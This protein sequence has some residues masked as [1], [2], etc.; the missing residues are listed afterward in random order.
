MKGNRAVL[1]MSKHL[2]IGALVLVVAY[3]FFE[4]YGAK[5]SA[6]QALLFV[7]VLVSVLLNQAFTWEWNWQRGKRDQE[8]RCYEERIE[9]LLEEIRDAR[10][11]CDCPSPR[12]G[13]TG[14]VVHR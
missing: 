9:K 7:V 13:R 2:L 6:E 1:A 10:V 14:A 12:A 8:Q 5:E 3:A 4:H 11:T